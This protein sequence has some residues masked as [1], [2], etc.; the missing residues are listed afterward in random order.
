VRQFFLDTVAKIKRGSVGKKVTLTGFA[1]LL[2]VV[3]TSMNGRQPQVHV[4]RSG[5]SGDLQCSWQRQ[6]QYQFEMNGQRLRMD[7]IANNIA[8]IETTRTSEG[9]AFQRRH[10]TMRPLMS[11]SYCLSPLLPSTLT[12]GLGEGV[13]VLRIERDTSRGPLQW[14]PSHPDAIRSGSAEG[15]V[16]LSN[17]VL[18]TE[19]VDLIAAS[20]LY[21]SSEAL[22]ESEKVIFHKTLD[23]IM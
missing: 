7:I 14:D 18:V 21:E 12:G 13:R 20:R 15:Y 9:G 16:E 22:L 4:V 5:N 23:I 8:N 17:V 6:L 19:M 1:V 11:Q 2:L 3:L 10:T